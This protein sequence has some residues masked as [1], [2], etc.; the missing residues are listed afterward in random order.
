MILTYSLCFMLERER[1]RD[2]VSVYVCVCVWWVNLLWRTH[3]LTNRILCAFW[4]RQCCIYRA[5]LNMLPVFVCWL[6]VSLVLALICTCCT[7]IIVCKGEGVGGMLGGGGAASFRIVDYTSVLD[8][9][10]CNRSR[11]LIRVEM[12]VTTAIGIDP[13]SGTAEG[14]YS[15]SC[16]DR[17][18]KYKVWP[19]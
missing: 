17:G 4:K 6:V 13:R 15:K 12:L 3:W 2:W 7:F 5:Q 18:N 8:P 10:H 19:K 14:M 16:S 9:V 11:C 1:E